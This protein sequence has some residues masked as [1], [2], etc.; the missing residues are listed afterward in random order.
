MITELSKVVEV[1]EDTIMSVNNIKSSM[2][3]IGTFIV[4]CVCLYLSYYYIPNNLKARL[5]WTT[6]KKEQ[7]SDSN[8]KGKYIFSLIFLKLGSFTQ[9]L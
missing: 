5:N 3:K 4:V 9:L 6:M 2:K 7:T 1:L 8:I